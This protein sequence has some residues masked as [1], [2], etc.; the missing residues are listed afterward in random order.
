MQG[1]ENTLCSLAANAVESSRLHFSGDLTWWLAAILA[2][3]GGLAAAAQKER[4]RRRRADETAAR[5]ARLR[6]MV[7]RMKSGSWRRLG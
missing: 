5:R 1:M 2:A 3:V 6:M 7:G 4:T